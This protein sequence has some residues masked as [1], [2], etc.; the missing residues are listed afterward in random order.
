MAWPR[1][2]D[3][4]WIWASD[5]LDATST[6]F[7]V[8]AAPRPADRVVFLRT[9]L[10]L[11]SAPDR[12]RCRVTADGKYWLYVNGH[13]IGRGPNRSEPAHLRYDTYDVTP[14]LQAGTNVIAAVVRAY[15]SPVAF[16]KPAAPIGM[17]GNGGLLLEA[18]IDG[19]HLAT[20]ATWRW[21]PAPYAR[22]APG[23][24]SVPA[25]EIVDGRLMPAGWTRAGFD[26]RDWQPVA[27][28]VPS[29]L[30]IHRAEPPT[31]PFGLLAA[32]ELPPLA[33]RVVEPAAV[34]AEGDD[35]GRPWRT[36]D[37]GR[38]L[39]G[40]P[41]VT[42]DADEGAVI[43]LSC[44][45]DLHDDG[46]PVTEPRRWS[47]QY[48]AS[49]RP[50]ETLEALESVGHRYLHA[51]VRAGT[52][53]SLSVS[54]NER[55]FPRPDG[56]TFSCNDDFLNELWL[57]GGRTLDACSTDAFMDCPGR[58]QRAWL[59][60]AYVQTV[61]SLVCNPDTR[62]ARWNATLHAQGSRTDG[63]R[64][65]V[66]AGDF[67]DLVTIPDFSL[68]WVRT[69][70]RLWEHLGDAGH[71]EPLIPRA[72]DALQWF[73]RHRGDDGLLEELSGWVFVDWA[74]TERR[75]N[76]AAIDALYALALD[77]LATIA[78]AIDDAGTARRARARADRT[79][80]A[81]ERYWDADRGVYVD[82]ANPTGGT[83]RRVSQHTNALAILCGA[84]AEDRWPA[85]IDT[86]TDD[87]RLVM[88]RHPGD[89]GPGSERRL[90]FHWTEPEHYAGTGR[91]DE[92][93]DVVLA[94]PFFT[95]FVHQAYVRAGRFDELFASFE[96]WRPLLARGNGVIEEYWKHEPGHGSRCHA[97]SGSPTYDLTTHVLGVRAASPGYRE[98]TVEP[99][100]GPLREAAG[101]VPTP[102]G[103][104][105]VRATAD[106]RVE[107]ELPPDVTRVGL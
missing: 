22:P 90:W 11:A 9:T 98:V 38:L 94:Q 97:W 43:E 72:V 66:A 59:G 84:A 23:W 86:I 26:D 51:K 17:L 77:D 68:H 21:H 89:N 8:E 7:Q 107:V 19:T 55:L 14:A 44:G 102:H 88:T 54:V 41:R 13:E 50:D 28:L 6:T 40:H 20:D 53:R 5:E 65:M 105:H 64:P 76:T 80:E 60:D 34:V 69:L 79:R 85:M 92:E 25:T 18:D 70:A 93:H 58:E 91:F 15:G 52:V 67:T 33:E 42:I 101:S 87:T 95:H 103:F 10:E 81:F 71:L 35:D 75:A 46:L 39:N 106:G 57:A 37:L 24:T 49:G 3:A 62:L 83:S 99:T 63:L 12:A 31:D 78:D 2:W 74:Q 36:V 45:E 82:A 1:R 32:S 61:I 29:G 48:T 104:I 4:R 27:E 56:A 47:L 30:G 16:W 96:R 100:L 73:E